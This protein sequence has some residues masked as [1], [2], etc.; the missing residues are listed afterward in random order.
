MQLFVNI[1]KDH[2]M[3]AKRKDDHRFMMMQIRCLLIGLLFLSGYAG[4]ACAQPVGTVKFA[5]VS[6]PAGYIR[7]LVLEPLVISH[8]GRIKPMLAR[9]WQWDDDRTL[10]VHLRTDVHFHDGAPFNAAAVK[11][12]FDFLQRW[13]SP[14]G[15]RDY[16]QEIRCEVIG[17]HTLRFGLKNP[18][19]LFLH[20]LSKL[21]QITP[22]RLKRLA[23]K[24]YDWGTLPDA[25]DW[26]TGPFRIEKGMVKTDAWSDEIRLTAF[27]GYWVPAY[28]KVQ[29]LL[30]YDL[31]RH[32]GWSRDEA[33]DNASR[34]VMEHEGQI[35]IVPAT[36]L[37]TL[38]IAQGQHA[39][40]EKIGRS[41]ILGLINMRKPKSPW[42]DVRLRRALNL[43]VNRD[44]LYA[45]MKG[46]VDLNA[47]LIPRGY[48]GHNEQLKPYLY[49]P[50]EANALIRDA[51]YGEGL[52]INVIFSYK[53][54]RIIPML[55]NM[56]AAAGFEPQ[57]VPMSIN[58]L[59]RKYQLNHLDQAVADQAWDVC[60]IKHF[61][62]TDHP[63]PDIYRRYFAKDGLL[64]WVDEDATLFGLIDEFA[65]VQ[66]ESQQN[67]I[68]QRCEAL[69]H[70]KAY[71]LTLYS[72][73]NTYAFNKNVLL[74]SEHADEQFFLRD[75]EL[76]PG[77]WSL[78]PEPSE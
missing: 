46:N 47:G 14:R 27:G 22:S 21:F 16:F 24:T 17:P 38:T 2:A 53:I 13:I 12:N 74:V 51:G 15:L 25:G 26:G 66:V 6:N 44:F 43:A 30:L 42:K 49:A 62:T 20:Q 67:A 9:T 28:P 3:A 36:Q 72:L 77:H 45:M 73:P 70:D 54:Q 18:D 32:F 63:Y 65:S 57:L 11:A 40:V 4:Q 23:G 75:I 35:D 64:R 34:T 68:L 39:R 48:I 55:D 76:A 8:W 5:Y 56:L 31:N 19:T 61:S 58:R 69:V 59:T 10:M 7:N 50:Q 60:I 37:Q 33:L 41:V 1:S 78:R 52:K 71:I 29:M